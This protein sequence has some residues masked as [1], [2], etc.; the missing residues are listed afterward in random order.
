[1]REVT[2]R[3]AAAEVR[4]P[5]GEAV[6]FRLDAERNLQ[7]PVGTGT[8]AITLERGTDRTRLMPGAPFAFGPGEA[9]LVAVRRWA[10]FTYSRSAGMP[11]VF[12]GFGLVLFGSFLLLFPAAVAREEERGEGRVMRFHLARGR[13]VLLRDWEERVGMTAHGRGGD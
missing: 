13:D 7:D 10:G 9:R 5:A 3:S 2:S 6:R 8:I 11:L 4:D 12:G 1:L